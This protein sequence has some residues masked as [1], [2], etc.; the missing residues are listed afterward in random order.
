MS[1]RITLKKGL[2]IKLQGEADA[3]KIFRVSS[4]L[5]AVK[6]TDFRA[7][8][9]R[10]E[11]RVGDAV[12]AGDP[13]F[14]DKYRPEV[15]FTAPVSGVIDAICRGEKRQLLAVTVKADE[16][17]TYKRF[18]VPPAG[19]LS[20]EKIIELLLESGLWPLIKQRPYDIIADPSAR[21]VAIFVTAFDSSPLAPDYRV[22]LQND[23]AA[24]R[25]GL[26]AL[27][28][29][30]G[31]ALHVN[32]R[33][34]DDWHFPDNARVNYFS[35]PHPAGNAGVQ[36]HHLAPLHKGEIAWVV[37]LPDAALIGRF[38]LG[39]QVDPRKTIALAGSEVT[40]PAYIETI[41]GARIGSIVEG[42]LRDRGRQRVIS[43]N[44]LTGDRVEMDSFLGFYHQMLTVIP[45]GDRPEFL[46]WAMPGFDK[47]SMSRTFPSFLFPGKRYRLDTNYHGEQRAFVASGQYEKVLPMDILPVYLLKAILAGDIE[48]MEQLGIY[49]IAP[50][51]LALCE[52]ACTSKIPVQEIVADGIALMMKELT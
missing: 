51:D 19:K 31:G 21:P 4:D 17:I 28:T 25:A 5:Y 13:L 2:D 30:A 27:D 34:K 38:L 37:N 16:K 23:A 39:G 32:A 18:D 12:R 10:L 47:F 46:G 15:K 11:V 8:V 50:E 22:L 26:E 29:L 1:K 40:E 33:E 42:R 24:I 3:R 43:G 20:R 49:E 7:L 35:G 14:S 6:P 52:F 45:E 41:A 36:I 9:P 48:K 44:V